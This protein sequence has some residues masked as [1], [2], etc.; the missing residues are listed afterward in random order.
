MLTEGQRA[1]LAQGAASWGV[2]LDAETLDRFA[3]FA[4]LLEEGN[5]R[6]NLTR[7]PTD[8]IVTLHFLDSLALIAVFTPAPGMQVID[9]GTGAGFPGVP[10]ALAFPG[11]QIT[12]LDAT[13]KRLAFLDAALAELGL[14]NA[15]TLHGRAEDLARLPEHRGRYGLVTARAVAKMPA[16]AG[17]LLPLAGQGGAVV[18]YKSREAGD[19]IEAARPQIAS[20]G[21]RIEAVADVTLPQTDI[22]RKLVLIRKER[23]TPTR[24]PRPSIRTGPR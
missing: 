23:P 5:Q 16:L 10:L 20:L 9:V 2:S 12:L 22:V 4:A 17:W 14:S 3:R 24:T 6:L 11:L 7:I 1:R 18:A 8:Q 19:E 15:R 21:G 13:R